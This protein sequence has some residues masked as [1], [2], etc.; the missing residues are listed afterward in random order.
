MFRSTR[1]SRHCEASSNRVGLPQPEA[2][3]KHD[4]DHTE[5]ARIDVDMSGDY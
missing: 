4:T 5:T 2:T 3:A 1:R